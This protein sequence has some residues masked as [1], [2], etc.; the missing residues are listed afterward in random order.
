ME[1]SVS[2]TVDLSSFRLDI[3]DTQL[4][5]QKLKEL[6]GLDEV[7]YR[8]DLRDGDVS[9]KYETPEELSNS[10]GLPEKIRSFTLSVHS[11]KGHTSVYTHGGMTRTRFNVDGS[12]GAWVAGV[13]QEI[14]EFVRRRRA[15]Y[16][17]LWSSQLGRTFWPL[18]FLMGSLP[19]I[20]AVFPSARAFYTPAGVLVAVVLILGAGGMVRHLLLPHSFI[21]VRRE[22]S[23]LAK[24]GNALT[25]VGG[26]VIALATLGTLAL[27]AYQVFRTPTLD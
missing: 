18:F 4:L 6:H 25:I 16:H 5:L 13:T 1:R 19:L 21:E 20:F 27:S 26:A 24:H 8:I 23:Y 11:T 2:K 22:E 15:W 3:S 14:K 9:Y 10:D 17:H 12:N 7:R